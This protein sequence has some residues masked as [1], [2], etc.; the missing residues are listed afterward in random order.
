MK[1]AEPTTDT[2]VGS[3][4]IWILAR[5]PHGRH[6]WCDPAYDTPETFRREWR[7]FLGGTEGKDSDR[8]LRW[9]FSV[10]EVADIPD[11][12]SEIVAE[13]ALETA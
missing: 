3:A 8:Y 7:A 4:Q 6:T 10:E 1:Q 2:L 11:W 13:M 5:W 9:Y 12:A